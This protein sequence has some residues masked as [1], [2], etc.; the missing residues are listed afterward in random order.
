MDPACHR[1]RDARASSSSAFLGFSCCTSKPTAISGASVERMRSASRTIESARKLLRYSASASG[2]A[3][4]SARASSG[5]PRPVPSAIEQDDPIPGQQLLEPAAALVGMR[6]LEPG[7]ALEPH[8][9]RTLRV[10]GML[11]GDDL[12]REDTDLRTRG[13]IPVDRHLDPVRDDDHAVDGDA[14]WH[15]RIVSLVRGERGLGADVDGTEASARQGG[16][17]RRDG[18][19]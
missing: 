4:G 3:K 7:T 8:D 12:A 13:L 5:A 18:A 15:P 1:A 16:E 9:R 11:G 17:H 2:L 6:G 10:G 14:S 19:H